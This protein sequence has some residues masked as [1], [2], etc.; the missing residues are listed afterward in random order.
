MTWSD[1]VAGGLLFL[2]DHGFHFGLHDDAHGLV[3]DVL[4]PVLGE[5]TALHVLA[6]ELLLDD[7]ACGLLHDGGLLGVLFDCC[8]LVSQIDFVSDED[9]GDVAD[10]LLQLG[11]PLRCEDG[12]LSCGR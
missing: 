12:V 6:L 11:V 8:V 1:Q 7:F 5:G 3:E 10:V 9:L 4:E 2:L